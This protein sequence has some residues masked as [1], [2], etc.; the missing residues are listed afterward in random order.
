MIGA[1]QRDQSPPLTASSKL[2][3]V[4]KVLTFE[5]NSPPGGAK[6]KLATKASA[7]S[8]ETK[9][10]LSVVHNMMNCLKSS[11]PVIINSNVSHISQKDSGLEGNSEVIGYR[12]SVKS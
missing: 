4:N 10:L 6:K 7:G 8:E 12:H 2:K 5:A 11:L 9:V 1:S 3:K